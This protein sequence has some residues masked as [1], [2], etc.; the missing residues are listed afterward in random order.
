LL[1]PFCSI[2]SFKKAGHA[3]NIGQQPMERRNLSNEEKRERVE[4]ARRMVEALQ[5]QILEQIETFADEHPDCDHS[6]LP[7]AL[8][9]A[10][11]AQCLKAYGAKGFD[12]ARE[13]AKFITDSMERA[14]HGSEGGFQM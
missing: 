4:S 3:D 2:A 9:Q 11:V 12:A 7:V 10:F 13:Q 5:D 8:G 14:Y 1:F 6:A